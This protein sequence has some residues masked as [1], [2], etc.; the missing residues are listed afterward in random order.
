MFDLSHYPGCP[1][2][3]TF[4]SLCQGWDTTNLN[5]PCQIGSFHG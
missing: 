1:I 3:G 5:Q 2:L 4:S